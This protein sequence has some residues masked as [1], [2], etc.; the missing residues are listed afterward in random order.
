MLDVIS[1]QDSSIFYICEEC[2]EYFINS[3]LLYLDNLVNTV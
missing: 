2:D 3:A 1:T